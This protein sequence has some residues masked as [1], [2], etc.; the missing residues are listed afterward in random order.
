M[1][2]VFC[3]SDRRL[4]RLILLSTLSIRREGSCFTC[5]ATSWIPPFLWMESRT[6]LL[7]SLLKLVR[8]QLSRGLHLPLRGEP[9]GQIPLLLVSDEEQWRQP[10]HAADRD[11]DELPDGGRAFR[12]RL[13]ELVRREVVL[14]QA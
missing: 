9:L 8:A 4:S 2:S 13:H 5:R 10:E 6:R 12:G 11:A 1:T 3:S 7:I 14:G